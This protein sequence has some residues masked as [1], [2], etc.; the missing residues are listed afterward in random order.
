MK[1]A[2]REFLHLAA[3][4]TR[5]AGPAGPPGGGGGGVDAVDFEAMGTAVL[6]QGHSHEVRQ[7]RCESSRHAFILGRGEDGN[8]SF[9]VS[10]KISV[11]EIE[12]N[13]Q[14]IWIVS[15]ER[16][17]I[18]YFPILGHEIYDGDVFTQY[19]VRADHAV[20]VKLTGIG[21][22]GRYTQALQYSP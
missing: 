2:R 20:Q 13:S 6:L 7:M 3:G 12:S 10:F 19:A 15:A 4:A 9:L 16:G 8:P 21:F 1:F 11:G 18:S 5:P 22:G 14:E 17:E